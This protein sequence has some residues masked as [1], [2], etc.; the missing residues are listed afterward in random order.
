MKAL[1]VCQ[2]YAE[3]IARGLKP[4]ENRTW[5]T[6]YR[7]PL[8]IHAGKSRAW[9]DPGDLEAY[10]GMEFGAIVA[11]VDLVDC[12]NHDGRARWGR[13]AA[14]YDHEH[15]NGPWCW[16]LQNVRRIDAVPCRGSQGLWDVPG[17]VIKTRPSAGARAFSL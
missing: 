8:G 9:M 17:L 10:P 6:T 12:L 15:A 7:G 3:L 1:T 4:I 5:P 2:P 14:L 13:Y 11:V 16:I